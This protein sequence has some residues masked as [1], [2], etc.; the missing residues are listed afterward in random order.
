MRRPTLLVVLVVLVARGQAI[1]INRHFRG[2]IFQNEGCSPSYCTVARAAPHL[3][4]LSA[5]TGEVLTASEERSCSCQCEAE[6]PTFREDTA[7]CVE[8]VQECHL[9]DFV[10]GDERERVPFVFLPLSGQLIYPSA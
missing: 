10:T 2:D 3:A 8:T 5:Q 4:P 9:A 6:F 1:T 7:A